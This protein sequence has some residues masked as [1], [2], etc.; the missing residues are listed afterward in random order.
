MA[1]NIHS[2]LT[3]KEVDAGSRLRDRGSK[4]KPKFRLILLSQQEA[5]RY[6][7]WLARLA[8]LSN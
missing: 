2:N 8:R 7:R 3:G 5:A 6:R 1:K 4:G